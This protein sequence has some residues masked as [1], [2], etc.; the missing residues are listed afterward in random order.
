MQRSIWII[1]VAS[2][3]LM[4]GALLYYNKPHPSV[5]S[6]DPDFRLSARELVQAFVE[7][8]AQANA[9]YGGKLVLVSGIVKD[10]L[11]D[12]NGMIVVMDGTVADASVSCYLDSS[13]IQ[14]MQALQTGDAVA[15]K[16]ICNGLMIDV[17]VDH[18]VVLKPES[19]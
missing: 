15:I 6:Q 2:V 4:V 18:A 16:G 11:S 10:K 12:E 19:K 3:V 5:V 13:Q 14:A 9:T 1:V 17:I 8:E 7:D